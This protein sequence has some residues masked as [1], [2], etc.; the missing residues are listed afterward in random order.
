MSERELF[1]G[2]PEFLAVA[3]SKSF[4]RAGEDLGVTAVAV[5]AAVR[6]LE[7]RL[8][9]TLFHRTTRRVELTAAGAILNDRMSRLT[10][11][12]NETLDQM[13]DRQ[14]TLSGQLRI[15]VQSLALDAVLT[16]ALIAFNAAHPDVQVEVDVREG[17]TDMIGEGFDLGI[18]LG[19]YIEDEMIA[20]RISRPVDWRVAAHPD[21]LVAHGR[22]QAPADILGH[23]C[24]RRIWPSTRRR[25][26]WE[27]QVDNRPLEV[28]PPGH[29]TVASF[30]VARR[31]VAAG[32]GLCYLT[33]DMIDMIP[34]P[35]E[36]VLD[37]FMPPPNYLYA[38]FSPAERDNRRI[39]AFLDC[40]RPLMARGGRERRS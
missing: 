9:M 37:T 13:R 16:P 2:M 22:P 36:T 21:Y 35:V 25:Y 12:L 8:G 27:F 38:Y 24:I 26:R 10:I 5:G 11:S 18:R 15:C 23:E 29:L 40:M 19:E 33:T 14:H 3:R 32:R 7:E 6:Q 39:R 34:S 1:K 17:R 28:D 30:A 31:L 4:R 20:V